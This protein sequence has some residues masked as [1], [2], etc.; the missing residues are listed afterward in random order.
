MKQAGTFAA[1]LAAACILATGSP[2]FG[3]RRVPHYIRTPRL[4][5]YSQLSRG[6]TGG[7]PSYYSFVR[8][9]QEQRRF[10]QYQVTQGNLLQ[11]QINFDRQ[12]LPTQVLQELEQG[13]IQRPGTRAGQPFAPAS[14][15]NLS[16]FYGQPLSGS[17]IGP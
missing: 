17:G 2:V 1:M 15:M 5:P 8:P 11:Q 9:I 7:M 4:S 13:I 14:F 16:H 3:Q 6:N 12:A 10:N